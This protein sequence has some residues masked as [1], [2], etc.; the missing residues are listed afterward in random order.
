MPELEFEFNQQDRELIVSQNPATLNGFMDYVRLTIYPMEA[1]DNVVVLPDSDKQAIF[2]SSLSENSFN[3]NISP[4]GEGEV[5][6]LRKKTIGG[7]DNNDFQIYKND[8]DIYIK[9]NEI[10]N[11]FELPEGDYRIQ[12]DF[13]NQFNF[14]DSFV[15]NKYQLQEKKSDLNL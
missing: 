2:Y 15:V 3:I 14:G 1:I 6:E 13:L 4:F 7:T 9:P 10:F 8:N 11:T 12:I 5:G